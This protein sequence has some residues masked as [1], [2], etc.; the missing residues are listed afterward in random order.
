MREPASA[1]VATA[2]SARANRTY[3]VRRGDNLWQISRKFD[4]PVEELRRLNGF[5]R[6]DTT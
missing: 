4:A 5:T 2:R 6:R 1:G 3:E